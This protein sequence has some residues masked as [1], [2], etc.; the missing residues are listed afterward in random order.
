ML[1]KAKMLDCGLCTTSM[2]KCLFYVILRRMF[3][4]DF[5]AVVS[6]DNLELLGIALTFEAATLNDGSG[7][8]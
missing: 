8:P 2:N 6:A 3:L 4:P 7:V 5:D 1:S